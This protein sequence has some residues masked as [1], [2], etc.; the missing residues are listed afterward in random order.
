[1]HAQTKP[2]RKK[3]PTYCYQCVNGPDLLMVEVI[4]GVATKVEPNFNAR[5]YHPAEGKVCVKPYGLVQKLYNPNRLLQ[6]MKRTNSSKGRNEDP[7]WKVISWD[8]AL[9]TVA[10]RMRALRDKGLVDENGDPR[11]A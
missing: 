9:D 1:M 8:E 3:V 5:A 11:F 7:G 10:A 2:D 4:D 6:P